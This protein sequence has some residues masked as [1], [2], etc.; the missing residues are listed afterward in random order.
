MEFVG[1][2]EINHVRHRH[3][4]LDIWEGMHRQVYEKAP[5]KRIDAIEQHQITREEAV[6][7]DAVTPTRNGTFSP[8]DRTV[9]RMF[10][11]NDGGLVRWP[12]IALIPIGFSLLL[13][14]AASELIKRIGFRTGHREQPFAVEHGKTNEEMLAQ[15][16]AAEREAEVA[17]AFATSGRH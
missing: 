8:E 10:G 9:W 5:Q 7:V 4:D 15:E 6:D 1:T 2:G 16:M 14:Q 3:K 12:V 13:L 11:G 17:R